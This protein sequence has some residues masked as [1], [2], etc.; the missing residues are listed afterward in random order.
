MQGLNICVCVHLKVHKQMNDFPI[1]QLS[2]TATHL[3][4]RNYVEKILGMGENNEAEEE[5]HIL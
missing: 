2:S 1:L 5:A 3:R 4:M